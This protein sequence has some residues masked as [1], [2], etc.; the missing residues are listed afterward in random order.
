MKNKNVLENIS[1]YLILNRLWHVLQTFVI[2]FIFNKEHI[3]TL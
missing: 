3:Q 2:N 1:T